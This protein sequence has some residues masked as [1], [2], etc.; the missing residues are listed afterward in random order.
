M[1][2][3]WPGRDGPAI[4]YISAAPSPEWQER[5]RHELVILGSTGSIGR[6][7]LDVVDSHPRHFHVLALSCARNV[8]MLARQARRYK[9][10][11]LAVLD[12]E[13]AYD[14][15]A[16]LPPDYQPEILVGPQGYAAA[17]S[18]PEADTVLSAQVGA[19]GLEGTLAAALAGKV[20][21][22]ANKESLVLAGELVRQICERTGAA[23]LP[24]DSEHNAIFQCLAAQGQ[25]AA[26]LL[27]TASGGPFRDCDAET[28]RHVTREQALNHPNWVMG[29]KISI[30]SASMMN[31]ALEVVEAFH[32]YGV[33][34]ERID[35]LVH[36]QSLVHSLVRLRDGSL[37]AQL[38]TADMRLPLA[39]CLLWPHTQ[40][41]GV[42]PLD[43]T[44]APALTFRQPD[45]ER[46]PALTFARRALR[47]RGG[48]CVVMNAANEAAVELFLAGRCSFLD[49]TRFIEEA[50]NRHAATRPGHTPLCGKLTAP[51]G[52][53]LALRAEVATYVER[54]ERLDQESRALVH[55][56]AGDG[57]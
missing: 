53:A 4:H 37:L 7:A 14:L 44:A 17:A 18:L 21:C 27:L 43:L 10:R 22:L 15:R 45:T 40:D 8:D 42:P 30:D 2:N 50:M 38:G 1:S 39:H 41:C 13:S 47:E 49:I 23:I 35:V 32:L 24:V 34:A 25:E 11:L 9:P 29:A 6:N 12:E 19:A 54:I 31:K 56:L 51:V 26:R 46:F 16:L 3:C 52:D 5:E 57:A 33:P 48:L 36:P 28:L 55:A 20:I